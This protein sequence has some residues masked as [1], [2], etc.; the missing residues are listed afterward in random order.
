MLRS[1]TI[2]IRFQQP[3]MNELNN[4]PHKRIYKDHDEQL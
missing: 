4:K 2:I 3:L 1:E